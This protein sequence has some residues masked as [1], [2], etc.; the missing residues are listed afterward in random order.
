MSFTANLRENPGKLPE[1]DEIRTAGAD[2]EGE[3]GNTKGSE[4]PECCLVEAA[5]YEGGL[6][7]NIIQ[8]SPEAAGKR[9]GGNLFPRIPDETGKLR[10]F[11]PY[12]P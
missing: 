10:S 11:S 8:K 7:P 3:A 9:P 5:V 12:L 2:I 1:R 6:H 4:S